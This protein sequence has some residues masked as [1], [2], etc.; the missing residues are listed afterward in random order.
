MKK[1]VIL[2]T[3]QCTDILGV[4]SDSET[5]WLAS[6]FHI[7]VPGFEFWLYSQVQFLVI[8]GSVTYPSW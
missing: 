3:Y 2:E 4:Y 1:G 6:I 8:L 5:E 7:G